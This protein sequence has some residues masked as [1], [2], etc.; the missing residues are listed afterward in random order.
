MEDLEQISLKLLLDIDEGFKIVTVS[1]RL[2]DFKRFKKLLIKP[3][4]TEWSFTLLSVFLNELKDWKMDEKNA[5][6]KRPRANK[7]TY[8]SFKLTSNENAKVF[9]LFTIEN[10]KISIKG[11][12]LFFEDW[13]NKNNIKE[14]W[15]QKSTFIRFTSSTSVALYRDSPL[16]FYPEKEFS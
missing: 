2:S 1:T 9:L 6:R 15:I 5:H 10:E 4:K 8:S 7:T 12:K 3:T 14:S 11:S 16:I 13:S